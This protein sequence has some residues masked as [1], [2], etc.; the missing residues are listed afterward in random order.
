M[1]Q[2]GGYLVS[3]HSPS[4]EHQNS[5]FAAVT[6]TLGTTYLAT[7]NGLVKYDGHRESLINTGGSVFD[8]A[9]DADEH[10]FLATS[11][12]LL[13][14]DKLKNEIQ[15]LMPA[16]DVSNIHQVLTTQK[17]V[18]GLS[19][20]AVYFKPN[21]GDSTFI[22]ETD[23]SGRLYNMYELDNRVFVN[24]EN[25]GALEINNRAMSSDVS[26][27]IE[28]ETIIFTVKNSQS[29]QYV[30]GTSHGQ[31]FTYEDGIIN[32]VDIDQQSFED[33]EPI[34]ALWYS[35]DIIVVGTMNSGVFFLN[36][37]TKKVELVVD[38]NTGL[39]DNEVMSLIQDENKGIS[40]VSQYAVSHIL[41]N[42]PIKNYEYY[43]GL[44]GEIT[45]TLHDGEKLYIGTNLGLFSLEQITDYEEEVSYINRRKNV[46]RP[47]SETKPKK[48]LFGFKRRKAKKE[49]ILEESEVI[50]TEKQI[51]KKAT[52]VHY[53]YKAV[54]KSI[55][56]ISHMRDLENGFVA[57]GLSGVFEIQS[58]KTK[59][60]TESSSRYLY[61]SVD[62]QKIFVCT[63]DEELLVFVRMNN[64]W[65]YRDVFTD[66]R[67][68]IDHVREYQGYYWLCSPDRIYKIKILN[69]EL[70]DVEEYA[71][72]NPYHAT[73]Y[74]KIIS[75]E[76]GFVS[77]SGVFKIEGDSIVSIKEP[78]PVDNVIID[79]QNEP[80]IKSN[81]DWIRPSQREDNSSVFNFFSDLKAIAYTEEATSYWVV[82]H[83]NEILQFNENAVIPPSSYFPYVD[84]V[85]SN[86][87][88]VLENKLVVVQDESKLSFDIS[89]PD[90]PNI[91]NTK[92]RYQLRG[93]SDSWSTWSSQ[94]T[95][96]FA[97]LPSGS[98]SLFVEAKNSFGEAYKIDPVSF[99]VL[100]PY[101]K[102][103]WFYALEFGIVLLLFLVS[104]KLKS[105]GYKYQLISR[106]LAFLTLVIVIEYLEAIMESYFHFENSP[107]FG[108][109]LQVVIAM[110]ILPFEGILKK[111]I[112]K[113]KVQIASYFEIKKKKE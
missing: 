87:R 28:K 82:T 66:F 84:G 45:S 103:P 52:G 44:S 110:I 40:V 109:V 58:G 99:D 46:F 81:D 83:D 11:V 91:F 23:L 102:R 21:D 41:P 79:N 3:K 77:S 93:M 38:Y 104:I 75:S 37:K 69:N 5:Y 43:E 1:A 65:V 59:R 62:K 15:S 53:L 71:L 26:D 30:L 14:M 29:G 34:S 72:K 112:F 111:Y 61:V 31:L 85:R 105:F 27:F 57:S 13:Q 88:L 68:R 64:E 48:G 8:V 33:S 47:T 54:N 49:N 106:M 9:L 98:Y 108:F 35:D 107:I 51:T 16:S 101:W 92:Y 50:V 42:I 60:I 63:G 89:H 70:D 19:A 76:I 78:F 17:A 100:P 18:Y 94:S 36:V 56:H 12:G 73:V 22:L 2:S 55:S 74:S 4:I 90:L 39:E 7:R 86:D 10:I 67:A 32:L 80:W 95:I 97:F 25:K 113:E 24:S 6:T 20:D 96:D